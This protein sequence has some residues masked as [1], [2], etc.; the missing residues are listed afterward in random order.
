MSY[1]QENRP[2]MGG[3]ADALAMQGRR[4]DS[5]LVHMNPMEV[6]ML[7]TMSPDGRLSINPETGL[8][9]AFKLKDIAAFA[10]PIAASIAFPMLAPAGLSAALGGVG[11]AALGAGLGGFGAGLIQGK[12]VGDSLIQGGLSGLMSYGLGSAFAPAAPGANIPTAA[13]AATGAPIGPDV[14]GESTA[15]MLGNVQPEVGSLT[16]VGGTGNSGFFGRLG[17]SVTGAAQTPLM[18]GTLSSIAPESYA[19]AVTAGA[20]PTYGSAL[21]AGGSGLLSSALLAPEEMPYDI[22]G[23][24]DMDA[25]YAS[26]IPDLEAGRRRGRAA[27]RSLNYPPSGSTGSQ[28]YGM[29][30]SPGGFGTFYA[31]DGGR[32]PTD[33]NINGEPHQLS[34][35]NQE[36]ADLLRSMG[37]SGQNVYGI[38]AYYDA[39][40]DGGD[41]AGPAGGGVGD[42]NDGGDAAGPAVSD[43]G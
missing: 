30:T 33:L 38:P 14:F 5:T 29:A 34:Y 31:A 4:G 3:L 24:D 32:V 22:A 20:A 2:A 19:K 28:Y 26:R 36:E 17:D 27:A 42:S 6:R 11:T 23:M 1:Y 41:A 21:T 15:S 13:P 43:R 16:T 12:G 8:P 37:G 39:S 7:E 9:E 25:Y 35:I 40:N 18:P 10:L